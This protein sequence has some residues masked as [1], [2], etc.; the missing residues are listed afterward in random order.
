VSVRPR[1]VLSFLAWSSGLSGGDRHLLEVAA[2]GREHVHVDVLAPPGAAETLGPLIGD[3]PV[4][5]LGTKVGPGPALAFEYVRRAVEVAVRRDQRTDVVVAAS[6]FVPDAAAVATFAR[7]GA[8]GV[9]YVYHLVAQRQDVRLRTLWSK[10]DERVALALLRRR[11]R[12]VFVSNDA[13]DALLRARGFTPVRTAVGV[14]VESF[15]RA[16]L[17]RRG[18][19][20]GR[21]THVKGP[22]DAI[23]AWSRVLH[24]VPD[25]RLVMV[26]TGPERE[27]AR[28]RA[29]QLGISDRVEWPGFVSEE[30]K[31]RLLSRS[32]LLLAPSYE[33]GWGIAVCEAFASSLPVVAYRLAV[34]DE[35]FGSAYLGA[36]VGDVDGIAELAV[37]TLTE[38]ALAERLA[39]EGRET[40]ERYDVQR[41]AELELE[42]IMR[43]L[44]RR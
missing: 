1:F 6:H 4:H 35:L 30:E 42:E 7:R 17:S 8:L 24:A 22:V 10:S 14:D 16:D 5:E 38:D 31:R 41:V 2:R 13:T 23:E 32:R 43:R 19:F 36:D 27:R 29:R 28:E 3:V 39:R 25:A 26:G 40:A 44:E 20:V 11:A 37:R 9:A 33:E 34:L 15:R 12:V 18:V 21:M